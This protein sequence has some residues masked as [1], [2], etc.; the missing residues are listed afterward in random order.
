MPLVSRVDDTPKTKNK[1]CRH[2]FKI[3]KDMG[4]K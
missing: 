1:Y 4:L 2:H 3:C